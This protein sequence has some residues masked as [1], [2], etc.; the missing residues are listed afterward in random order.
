M[1]IP[2]FP[3]APDVPYFADGTTWDSELQTCPDFLGQ[4]PICQH[5]DNS[6]LMSGQSLNLRL[7]PLLVQKSPGGVLAVTTNGFQ[8]RSGRSFQ[9]YAGIRK[10]LYL[11]CQCFIPG[12]NS[13]TYAHIDY[14]PRP[15]RISL[16]PKKRTSHY[17]QPFHPIY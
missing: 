5:L 4:V 7:L 16:I 8:I 11:I 1:K 10:N 9:H 12:N 17:S 13:H 3:D 15:D 2:P 14:R 6:A